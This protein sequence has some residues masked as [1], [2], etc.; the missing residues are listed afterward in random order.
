MLLM[1]EHWS[2]PST[3]AL[4]WHTVGT[5]ITLVGVPFE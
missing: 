5:S 1:K 3:M 4:D 2:E